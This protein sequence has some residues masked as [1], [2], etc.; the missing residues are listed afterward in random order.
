MSRSMGVALDREAEWSLF[1][2]AGNLLRSG[3]SALVPL[4]DL[5]TGRLILRVD[6]RTF[7]VALFR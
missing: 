1:D 4:H 2:P 6:G 7:N 5:P 3:T